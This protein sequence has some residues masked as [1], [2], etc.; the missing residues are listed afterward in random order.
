[1]NIWPP[2]WVTGGFTPG[3]LG[4]STTVV[5]N[6]PFYVISPVTSTTVVEVPVWQDYSRPLQAPP[7]TFV[8]GDDTSVES[9]DTPQSDPEMDEA[10]ALFDEARD[11]FKSENFEHALEAIDAAITLLPSDATLH[12][13]RALCLFAMKDFQQ[14]AATIYSVL[15][16]G[17]GWNWETLVS[18]YR[19]VETHTQQLRA[20]EAHVREDPDDAAAAFLLAYHYMTMGHL[21]EAVRMWE[22]VAGLLPEDQLTAQLIEAFRPDVAEPPAPAPPQ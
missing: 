15:A 9:D 8:E 6:N 14:A 12:E 20:L 1:V 7:E 19:N 4:H 13:F 18:L 5:Y 2:L 3:W 22:R 11:A 10:M 21:D 17:P 16:A